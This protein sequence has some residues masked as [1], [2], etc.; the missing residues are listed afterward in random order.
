[1]VRVIDRRIKGSAQRCVC[2]R[3]GSPGPSSL[4]VAKLLLPSPFGPAIG[5]PDLPTKIR[6]SVGLKV[7]FRAHTWSPETRQ[8]IMSH[9]NTAQPLLTG[10][11]HLWPVMSAQ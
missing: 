4:L 5:E 6:P 7:I 3:T 11:R 10:H 9:T 2:L 1:M 8:S